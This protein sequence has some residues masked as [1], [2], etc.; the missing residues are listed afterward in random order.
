MKIDH[1][2]PL[3]PN[4]TENQTF[5]CKHSNPN[6]CRDY[7]LADICAF[8][9]TDTICKKPPRGWQKRFQLLKDENLKE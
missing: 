7:D 6:T 4:D 3:S 5:G 1:N 2:A 8:V 9:R